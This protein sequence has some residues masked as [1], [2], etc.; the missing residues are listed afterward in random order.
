[1]ACAKDS[2]MN[3]VHEVTEQEKKSGNAMINY[4]PPHSGIGTAR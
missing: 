1:M 4:A 3:G 2:I